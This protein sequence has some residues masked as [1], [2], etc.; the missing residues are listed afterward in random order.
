MLCDSKRKFIELTFFY[1][2]KPFLPLTKN[3]L[4]LRS[5]PITSPSLLHRYSIETMDLRWSNDG[6]SSDVRRKII[7]ISAV[8]LLLIVFA[9][10]SIYFLRREASQFPQ[11]QFVEN[12][13]NEENGT[14]FVN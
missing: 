6:V 3:Q 10:G 9:S 8:V 13:E 2:E 1:C 12:G 11:P 5:Y 7:G 14:A 4:F